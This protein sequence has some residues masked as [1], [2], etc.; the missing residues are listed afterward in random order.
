LLGELIG[1]RYFDLPMGERQARQR[2]LPGPGKPKRRRLQVVD[3]AA[4]LRRPGQGFGTLDY[5]TD[6][7]CRGC[8]T[9]G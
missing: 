5:V 9:A 7:R 8:C 6:V 3:L 4:A 2:S 1:S